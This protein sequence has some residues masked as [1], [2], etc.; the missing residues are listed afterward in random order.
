MALVVRPDVGYEGDAE[1]FAEPA[2]GLRRPVLPVGYETSELGI[3][4]ADDLGRVFY[5]HW[6]GPY[7]LGHDVYEAFARRLSGSTL[8]DA[9]DLYA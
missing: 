2:G 4:L 6:S 7:F 5:R 1:D 3:V 9:E 8:R